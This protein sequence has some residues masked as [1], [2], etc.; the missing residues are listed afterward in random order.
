MKLIVI[1]KALLWEVVNGVNIPFST[2]E[3]GVLVKLGQILLYL[4]LM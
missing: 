3:W 1:K 4:S 2:R